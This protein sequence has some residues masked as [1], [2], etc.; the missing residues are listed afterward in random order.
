MIRASEVFKRLQLF[1]RFLVILKLFP[2]AGRLKAAWTLSTNFTF[3]DLES[4]G[5]SAN[6][7]DD[8]VGCDGNVN[9]VE[10]RTS[11]K[12]HTKLF[13][14]LIT[15]T[16]WFNLAPHPT[17]PSIIVTNPPH[18]PFPKVPSRRHLEIDSRLSPD[19]KCNFSSSLITENYS[20]SCLHV[21]LT[22]SSTFAS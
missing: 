7:G 19:R 11:S 21:S 4:V 2:R 18:T 20:K 8:Q 1:S 22:S 9:E 13:F 14:Y 5:V 15:I 6:V 3:L 10:L 16:W 17:H 12:T